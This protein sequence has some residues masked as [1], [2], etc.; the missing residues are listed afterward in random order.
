MSIYLPIYLI[1]LPT[2]LSIYLS[3]YLS[4]YLSIKLSIFL[5]L[6]LSINLSIYLFINLSIH[7]S[8]YLYILLTRCT[9]P[10]ACHAKRHLNL[11]QRS[12]HVVFC[13]FSLRNVL[14]ATTACTFSTLQLP[15]VVRTP[16]IFNILTS[17]CVP[18]ATTACAFRHRNFQKWS[19]AGVFCTFTTARYFS[20]LIWPAGS[21]P[22]ALA[23]LLFDHPETQIIGKYSASRLSYLFAHL[24]FLSS[25]LSLLF[26]FLLIFL[27]S[28]PL[29]CFSSIH[30]AGNLTSKFPST[31]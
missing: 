15:K 19:E 20:S 7:P 5:S 9:I 23:R 24:H 27:F 3:I 1:Y 17:K 26:F 25:Y 18:R 28:L 16:S 31:K 29:L 8:I 14:S 30:I 6:F 22:A 4:V 11:K 10:C 12:E 21:A 13:A 2:Y